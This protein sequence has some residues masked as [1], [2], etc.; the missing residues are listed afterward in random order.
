MN[1][2]ELGLDWEERPRHEDKSLGLVAK[3]ELPA[4]K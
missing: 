2:R 1:S 4:P 3:D